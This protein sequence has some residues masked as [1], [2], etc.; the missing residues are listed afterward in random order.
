MIMPACIAELAAWNAKTGG[1]GGELG[2]HTHNAQ[3]LQT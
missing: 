1:G 2:K 3:G